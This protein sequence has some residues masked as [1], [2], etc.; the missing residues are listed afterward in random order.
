[1]VSTFMG[2]FGLAPPDEPS[3]SHRKPVWSLLASALAPWA[4]VLGAWKALVAGTLPWGARCPA[5]LLT[6]RSSQR[7]IQSTSAEPSHAP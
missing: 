6:A 2:E 4:A 5:H 7:S 1:M 3:A